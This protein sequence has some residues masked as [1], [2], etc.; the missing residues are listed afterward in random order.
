MLAE[1]LPGLGFVLGGG[2]SVLGWLTWRE[3][4]QLR[5]ELRAQDTATGNKLAVLEKLTCVDSLTG[6][7]NERMYRAELAPRLR[8]RSPLALIYIDLD[9]L[10]TLNDTRGHLAGDLMIR[11]AAKEIRSSIQREADRNGIFRRGDAADEFIVLLD[12]DTITA[13]LKRAEDILISIRASGFTASIG[14]TWWEP[15]VVAGSDDLERF[16][17]L[18]MA[19]AKDAGRDCVRWAMYPGCK[20]LLIEH[21]RPA[22]LPLTASKRATDSCIPVEII[23]QTERVEVPSRHAA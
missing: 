20:D 12:T 6:L 2:L 23:D 5:A 10:K 19:R 15:S 11:T 17:E 13:A 1:L 14:V 4:N 9:G 16:A 21:D 3:V 22:A 18:Q 8:G 7:R